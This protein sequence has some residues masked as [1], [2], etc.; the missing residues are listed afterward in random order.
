MRKS[1]QCVLAKE[2]ACTQLLD[3][4]KIT[5]VRTKTASD[6]EHRQRQVQSQNLKYF[7]LLASALPEEAR[8]HNR[9]GELANGELPSSSA[10]VIPAALPS[11]P[12][13]S[14]AGHTN[15][16]QSGAFASDRERERPSASGGGGGGKERSTRKNLSTGKSG[17]AV[18]AA[19]GESG[20]G[21][22]GAGLTSRSD[23]ATS[24]SRGSLHPATIPAA[25]CDSTLNS[26][27]VRLGVEF[28]PLA[29]IKDPYCPS[30]RVSYLPLSIYAF[31]M[32]Q[33][34]EDGCG[35]VIDV[36]TCV[37]HDLGPSFTPTTLRI[38]QTVR[39]KC[40]SMNVQNLLVCGLSR[41]GRPASLGHVMVVQRAPQMSDRAFF[42]NDADSIVL[43]GADGCSP[44]VCSTNWGDAGSPTA[45]SNSSLSGHED[46]SAAMTV[47]SGSANTNKKAVA[48]GTPLSHQG[49]SP[50]SKSSRGGQSADSS[51]V[52]AS[53]SSPTAIVT[54]S[55][56]TK[57]GANG[58]QKDSSLSKLEE[59]LRRLRSER[60][61]LHATEVDLRSQVARL[62]AIERASLTENSQMRQELE[63]LQ[64]KLSSANQRLQ[65]HFAVPS[66]TEVGNRKLTLLTGSSSPEL[67]IGWYLTVK[68]LDRS[69]FSPF[70][71]TDTERSNL[72][73]LEKRLAEERRQRTTLEQQLVAEKRARKEAE[74]KEAAKT[75]PASSQ[76]SK[77]VGK[78]VGTNR[79]GTGTAAPG[80]GAVGSPSSTVN[81]NACTSETCSSRL[82]E[83]E[84]QLKSVTRDLAAKEVQLASLRSSRATAA[85]ATSS[86]TNSV[87]S[88]SSSGTSNAAGT[89]EGQQK[90]RKQQQQ[91]QQQQLVSAAQTNTERR[92]S[93]LAMQLSEMQEENMRLTAILKGEDKM[94]QELLTAYH[95]SLKEITELTS[96]LTR[97]EFQIV[98]LSSRL[99]GL[100]PPNCD[101]LCGVVNS[102]SGGK[103]VALGYHHSA[104][105]SDP[106]SLCR[107]PSASDSY[108]GGVPDPIT[109]RYNPVS[110][111]HI[112]YM[113]GSGNGFGGNAGAD[114]GGSNVFL[115][116]N[117][118][119]DSLFAVSDF[120]GL[121]SPSSAVAATFSSSPWPK[122]PSATPCSSTSALN[123]SLSSSCTFQFPPSNT[124]SFDP[125]C[126]D[127]VGGSGGGSTGGRN[128]F[129]DS[130]LSAAAGGSVAFTRSHTSADERLHADSFG[131]E[132]LLS[133]HQHNHPPPS[134]HHHQQQQQQS[135]RMMMEEEYRFPSTGSSFGGAKRILSAS[136]HAPSPP[137]PASSSSSAFHHHHQQQQQHQYLHGAFNV[138]LAPTCLS[139]FASHQQSAAYSGGGGGPENMSTPAYLNQLR[140]QLAQTAAGAAP[141]S[142]S[143]PTGLDHHQSQSH[144][145]G[146]M[147]GSGGGCRGPSPA[148]SALS[149][150]TDKIVGDCADD[151]DNVGVGGEM[152]VTSSAAAD[153]SAE[154]VAATATTTTTSDASMAALAT[155]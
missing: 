117:S 66:G 92:I 6:C 146:E 100:V 72:Q 94:K 40:D 133:Q 113:N 18:T 140:S 102:V 2:F 45:S 138:S 149:R 142:S 33:C 9:I 93:E 143:P 14:A 109:S 76:S 101:Y 110:T 148:F 121:S 7:Y 53:S 3:I 20:G 51:T 46:I 129:S 77:A 107:R 99:D 120:G 82:R 39:V 55:T 58:R 71:T 15:L 83:L 44:S 95:T 16:L 134:H 122:Q 88:S 63:Q 127:Y 98:D 116:R 137:P 79:P 141:G 65:Q 73:A 11:I 41:R 26:F 119:L 128:G 59:E 130:L 152:L 87:F 28:P 50:C 56:T 62:T 24:T 150:A 75:V 114:S 38:G 90:M 151:E 37:T 69:T 153:S 5:T 8:S 145:L 124:P 54:S 103:S 67:F 105:S 10:S 48:S 60:Q 115:N 97:K 106:S 19:A 96:T 47:M 85:P 70:C 131:P 118:D 12:S 29:I 35:A 89:T 23:A 86:T 49:T 125:P 64:S 43:K 132:S 91:Q 32:F 74:E 123:A 27:R 4:L 104:Q 84:A 21:G 108:C 139:N 22:G 135:H 155:T 17:A 112:P 34:P 61:N 30:P 78:L 81:T 144:H 57:S 36:G 1:K 154:S 68:L 13:S 147:P 111:R 31:T 80:R 42:A 52:S 25:A 126:M 136:A